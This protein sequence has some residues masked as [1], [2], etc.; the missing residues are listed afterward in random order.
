MGL[1]PRPQNAS[2]NFLR[3]RA[4]NFSDTEVVPLRQADMVVGVSFMPDMKA[5]EV[6][7][8][9]KL[10]T[11]GIVEDD[12]N[13]SS[14]LRS[15]IDNAPGYRCVCVCENAKIAMAEI[16][17][18]RP[19][20]VLMDINLPGESGIAC[21]ARLKHEMPALQIIMLTVFREPK[22][23]FQSLKAGACGYLLKR[24][25][26][27]EILDAIAEVRNGGAPMSGNIA[28]MVVE[29]FHE[30][31]VQ[32]SEDE[33]LS[34]REEEVLSLLSKGLVNK[35]IGEQMHISKDTVRAHLRKIY[36]KLHVRCRVE[37]INKYLERRDFP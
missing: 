34:Q 1:L 30:H 14:S 23:L 20:V 8:S 27:E 21:T 18:H 3:D 31:A 32:S 28:R 29:A 4:S 9:P 13:I 36:E 17:R 5:S 6:H 15:L 26:P 35:E 10:T 7:V 25:N 37:A 2:Q 19:D 12:P 11:I 24:S 33:K 22:A 16:P